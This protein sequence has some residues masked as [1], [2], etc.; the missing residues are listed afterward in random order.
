MNVDIVQRNVYTLR[1]NN[2]LKQTCTTYGP[3][4]VERFAATRV[5]YVD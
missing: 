5:K 3:R 4:A 1:A 2:T